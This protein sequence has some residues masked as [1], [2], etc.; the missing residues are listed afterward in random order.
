MTTVSRNATGFSRVADYQD[1]LT[2]YTI[3]EGQHF[4][5][6]RI[7]KS[8]NRP[9]RV[10]WR[11]RFAANC[12]YDLKDNDQKDWNK[13]CGLFYNLFNTRDNTV[14]V[15]WRWN[16]DRARMEL[17]AYYHVDGSRDFTKPLL[18]VALEEDLQVEIQIDYT[19]KEY[20]VVLL[21]SSDG[22]RVENTMAF[23]HNRGTCWEINT[24]FGGNRVAPQ[25][26]TVFKGY[27]N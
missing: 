1:E 20:T 11:V 27:L 9:E 4:C 14:M 6:P 12:D 22:Q 7:F 2:A 15:G 23:T 24:Y 26:V 3:S 21:R 25:D 17:C 19:K 18:D 16:K 13:L 8:R 5:F 10:A